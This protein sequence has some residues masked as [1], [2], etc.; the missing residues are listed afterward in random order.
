[1][2]RIYSK[3]GPSSN[4]VGRPVKETKAEAAGAATA[5]NVTPTAQPEGNTPGEEKKAQD[6][7]KN[8][9]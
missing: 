1:M 4:K 6:G 2:P 8:G 9:Q 5:A 3:T 7:P